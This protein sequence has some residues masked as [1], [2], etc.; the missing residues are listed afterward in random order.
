MKFSHIKYEN[1][2]PP[3][4]EAYN[5]Q[6]VSALLADYGFITIRLSDDWQGADFIAQHIYGEF[7]KAQLKGR[8]TFDKKYKGRDLYICCPVNGHW[9]LYPHDEMLEKVVTMKNLDSTK[10]WAKDG[11]VHWPKPPEDIQALLKPF[12]L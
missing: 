8:V 9:H 11:I 12:R 3:Q 7:L 6:K 10:H 5:F 1:L 2:S 4:Q